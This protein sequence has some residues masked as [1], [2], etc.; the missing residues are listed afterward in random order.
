MDRQTRRIFRYRPTPAI[1]FSG[2]A[3]CMDSVVSHLGW[4]LVP[5]RSVRR[6]LDPLVPGV[7]TSPSVRSPQ[8]RSAEHSTIRR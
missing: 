5:C 6:N 2:R 1:R 3:R 8:A 7:A 4:P